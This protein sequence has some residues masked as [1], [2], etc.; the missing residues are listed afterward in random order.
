[1]S[2]PPKPPR[3]SEPPFSSSS[4]S[5]TPSTVSHRIRARRLLGPAGTNRRIRHNG[6]IPFLF[7]PRQVLG[8]HGNRFLQRPGSN[9][10]PPSEFCILRRE[11][12]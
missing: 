1:M 9:T 7:V 6:R 10:S 8:R 11:N 12:R 3:P 2:P 5:S 4:S